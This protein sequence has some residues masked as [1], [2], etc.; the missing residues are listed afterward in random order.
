MTT[1]VCEDF[2]SLSGE[3]VLTGIPTVFVRFFGCNMPGCPGF[4]QPDPSDK[5]TY[6]NIEITDI[7][8]SPKYGCDSPKSWCVKFKNYSIPYETGE[9]L[10]KYLRNKYTFEQLRNLSITGGEPLLHQKFIIEFLNCLYDECIELNKDSTV[11]FE[12]NGS[13]ALTND[14]I[15]DMFGEKLDKLHFLFNISPK[16]NCVAGVDENVSIKIDT[17]V[18]FLEYKEQ[19]FCDVKL[20]FV[21]NG[22]ERAYKRVKEIQSQINEKI[23]LEPTDILLMPVGAF[24]IDNSI[25]QKTAEVCLENN[26]RYCERVHTIIWGSKTGV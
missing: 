24:D 10:Y 18:K 1:F 25:R 14:F 2:Y 16:L 23:E 20:K 4:G 3:S 22:D 12:T 6:H 8:H 7:N 11:A 19:G 26:F 13:I 17:L 5:T 9:D 21:F 15:Y